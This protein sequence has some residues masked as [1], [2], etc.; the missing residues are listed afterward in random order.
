MNKQQIPFSFRLDID[1]SF[2]NFYGGQNHQLA[3]NSLRLQAEGG[4]DKF[5]FL[6]GF[7]GLSHLLQAS[8]LLAE[9]Q[10]KISRYL[11]IKELL[12]YDPETVFEALEESDLICLDD[13]DSV[14]GNADWELALFNLYNRLL[15][16]KTSLLVSSHTSLAD[17]PLGLADLRSRL[18]SF[19][20]FRLPD[21]SETERVKAFQ[22]R[23]KLRGMD[24]SDSLAEY[25]YARCHREFSSLL[26]VLDRL[27]QT[28]LV[29]KRRLT[30]PFVK[31]VMGW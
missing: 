13:V 27:D 19:A 26:A 31:E 15:M 8:C 22:L 4:G 25:I 28:S 18:Q 14:V 6:S 12:D 24:V 3:L 30:I 7:S 9:Q 23:S 2:D 17:M 20:F 16:T 21:L 5:L 29:E 10:Q 1:A 11:P